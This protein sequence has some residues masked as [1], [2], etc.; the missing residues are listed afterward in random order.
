MTEETPTKT[1]A[2]TTIVPAPPT[3]DVNLQNMVKLLMQGQQPPTT[4][5]AQAETANPYLP[6]ATAA[7]PPYAQAQPLIDI[8]SLP[9]TAV[10]SHQLGGAVPKNKTP[11]PPAAP[12]IQPAKIAQVPIQ[13]ILQ[14]GL[15]QLNPQ[16]ELAKERVVKALMQRQHGVVPQTATAKG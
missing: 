11:A 4:Q 13:N 6:D 12:E 9:A 1:E 16:V 10:R 7:A 15:H 5:A 3:W 8:N 2:P 14:M